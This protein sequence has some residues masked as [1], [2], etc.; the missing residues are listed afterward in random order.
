MLAV[1]VWRCSQGAGHGVCKGGPW[2]LWVLVR[3]LFGVLNSRWC[4]VLVWQWS[5]GAGLGAVLGVVRSTHDAAVRVLFGVLQV[6][7]SRSGRI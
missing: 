3:V 1:L 2:C 5:Q 7:A 4:A 6:L